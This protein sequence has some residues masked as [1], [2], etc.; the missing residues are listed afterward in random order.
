MELGSHSVLHTLHFAATLGTCLAGLDT[1]LHPTELL[2][3]VR[4]G[5]A[6]FGAQS[7]KTMLKGR[8]SELEVG[9][10]LTDLRAAHQEAEMFWFDVLSTAFEAVVQCGLQTD[11][12]AVAARLDTGLHGWFGV[13]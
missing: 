7:A 1:F 13:G 6:N 9:R 10:Y 12:M 4:T 11:L 2:T 5:L 3:I 8:A